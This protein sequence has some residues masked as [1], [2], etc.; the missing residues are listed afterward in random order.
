MKFFLTDKIADV[1][2]SRRNLRALLAKLDGHPPDSNCTITKMSEDLSQRLILRAEP[3]EKHYGD[4]PYPPGGMHPSTERA[5][6]IEPLSPVHPPE[7]CP[8]CV[9]VGALSLVE[10]TSYD[11]YRCGDGFVAR[12]G[13]DGDYLSNTTFG[14]GLP[15]FA[16]GWRAVLYTSDDDPN[17]RA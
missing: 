10:G 15:I 2:V 3:D 1:T 13:V 17:A 16:N 14:G 11:I 7:D 12:F 4:R 5:M 9:F 6:E 8:E